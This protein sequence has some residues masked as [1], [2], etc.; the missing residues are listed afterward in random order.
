MTT[1]PDN[2]MS[3]YTTRV[4]IKV[5]DDHLVAKGSLYLWRFNI[6]NININLQTY[7]VSKTM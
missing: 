1:I 2:I 7:V 5:Y 6:E 4:N 3:I